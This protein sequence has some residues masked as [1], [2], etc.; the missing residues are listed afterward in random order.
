MMFALWIAVTLRRPCLRA[1]S[2]AYRAIRVDAYS[3]M[4]FRDSTTP[5]AVAADV[6]AR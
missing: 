2:K 3:V 5:G 6:L 1:Y 4:I